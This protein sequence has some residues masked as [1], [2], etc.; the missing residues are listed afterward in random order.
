MQINV[1]TKKEMITQDTC[2]KLHVERGSEE[3]DSVFQGWIECGYRT[4]AAYLYHIAKW[5]KY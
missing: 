3:K 2:D 4:V 5:L 1:G